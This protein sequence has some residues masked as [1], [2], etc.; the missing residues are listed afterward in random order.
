[1]EYIN[2]Q[3]KEEKIKQHLDFYQALSHGTYFD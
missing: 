2:A 1:M 3:H